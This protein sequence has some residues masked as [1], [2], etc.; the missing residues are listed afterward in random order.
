VLLTDSR[1]HVIP[2][3]LFH[4]ESMAAALRG[5]EAVLS[6][7]G[8]AVLARTTQRRDFGRALTGAMQ[9]SSVR[10]VLVVSS[11]LLFPDAGVLAFLL[12]HSLFRNVVHDAAEMEQP[13]L[14]SPL[15]WTI[16]RP[17][18]LTNKAATRRYRVRDDHQPKGGMTISRADVADF[19]LREVEERQHIRRIVGVS[20]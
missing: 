20:N 18:R 8:P 13:F 11:G 4:R 1:L 3:D 7:F 16:V 17:P 19:M 9:D 10:Q 14:D 2:G 12:R 15:D 5:H 6:A